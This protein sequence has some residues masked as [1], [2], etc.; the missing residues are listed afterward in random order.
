MASAM[1]YNSASVPIPFA[2]LTAWMRNRQLSG[3]YPFAGSILSML[4]EKT[5]GPAP[6]RPMA[7]GNPVSSQKPV[8]RDSA[9][10]S[11]SANGMPFFFA[12][13]FAPYKR[14]SQGCATLVFWKFCRFLSLRT[15]M[16]PAYRAWFRP[17]I[18]ARNSGS[19]AYFSRLRALIS[20]PCTARVRSFLDFQRH[21]LQQYFWRACFGVNSVPQIAQEIGVVF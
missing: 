8:H 17:S 5:C 12:R 11:V 4:G 19:L 9:H 21:C 7:K 6:R 15:S 1:A 18:F 14:L 20:S 3:V 2:A 13:L 16:S 10:A